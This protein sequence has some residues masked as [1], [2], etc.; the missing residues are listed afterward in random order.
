MTAAPQ[1]RPLG[2]GEV[3]DVALKIVWRNAGTLVRVV[4]FVVFPVEVVSALVTASA[5]PSQ[6]NTG[7]TFTTTATRPNGSD[8]EAILAAGLVVLL[9]SLLGSTLASGACFR[10]IASAYLGERTGWRASLGYAL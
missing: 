5:D 7:S 4:V 3:L 9:L 10:A 1:L 8:L 2:I 6:L